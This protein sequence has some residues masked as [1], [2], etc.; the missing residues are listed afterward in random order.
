G[1]AVTVTVESS[2]LTTV[3]MP[4]P[5]TTTTIVKGVPAKGKPGADDPPGST[6]LSA[7]RTADEVPTEPK[8]ADGAFDGVA[9][10]VL[11]A[12]APFAKTGAG[13]FHVVPGTSGPIGDG[14]QVRTLTIE[15]EDGIE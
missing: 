13:T 2:V 12:G 10:G 5:G 8:D 3:T 11:P 4:G 6:A 14:G 9:L 1:T 15:V 7:A